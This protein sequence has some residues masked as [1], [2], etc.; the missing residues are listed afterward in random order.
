MI[1]TLQIHPSPFHST[2]LASRTKCLGHGII[3]SRLCSGFTS[4]PTP[5]TQQLE[6]ATPSCCWLATHRCFVSNL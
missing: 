4:S 5:E 3:T 6:R 1:Q 2:Q